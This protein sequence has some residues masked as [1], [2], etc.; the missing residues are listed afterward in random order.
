MIL[1]LSVLFS[2]ENC[3]ETREVALTMS[4]FAS[5]MGVFPI[6]EKKPFELHF[7]NVENKRLLIQ[8]EV[9]VTIIIPCDRCLS[10]VPMKLSIAIDKEIALGGEVASVPEEDV[11]EQSA[12]LD[13][14]RLD[15]DRLLYGEILVNWP[16]KVLCREDCKGLC[17]KCGS[18]LNDGTCKC[19]QFVPDPRMAAFQDVFNKFK[20]V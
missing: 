20:E 6:A 18:N 10:D 13:G 3:E 16:M 17:K 1:D 5:K 7:T 11:F 15:V 19:D 2:N 4:S 8:G 14:V 9:D 12:Y